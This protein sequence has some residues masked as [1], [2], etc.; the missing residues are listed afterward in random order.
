MTSNILRNSIIIIG[1]IAIYIFIDYILFQIFNIFF[2]IEYTNAFYIGESFGVITLL[3]A[4]LCL[5]FMLEL[6]KNNKDK[7]HL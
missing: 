4:I 3:I 5:R 1:A 6:L 7:I 2:A